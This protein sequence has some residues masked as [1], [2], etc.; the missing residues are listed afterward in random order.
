[1][2]ALSKIRVVPGYDDDQQR[3]TEIHGDILEAV[4][5][6]VPL[7]HLIPAS[8]V[9]RSWSRAVY[10]SLR[11]FNPIKPW[12]VIH[13]QSTRS[14]YAATTRAYDPRS[15]LWID[16]TQTPQIQYDSALRS[17]DSNLLYMLSQSK[18]SFSVD[19][20][21]LTWNHVQA[22]LLWRTDPIVAVVGHRI[23]VAG[24]TCDFEEDPFAVE[25]Y[26]LESNQWST[27]VS[28]PA[29]LKG[30]AS[31]SWLSIATNNQA[32]F[33]SEKHSGLTHSFDPE[34]MNWSDPYSLRPDPRICYSVVGFCG[35]KLILIGLI[36]EAEEVEG[37]KIWEVDCESMECE[38]IGEM[39]AKFVKKL[40]SEMFQVS[41][42]NVCT[43]GNTAY[44][45][46][47]MEVEEVF[48]CEFT[49]GG[50]RWGNI[51]NIDRNLM[52]RLVLTC[53]MVGMSDIR[54]AMSTGDRKF[55]LKNSS[56]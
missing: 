50:C 51:E 31:S 11:H 41:S 34:T 15:K 21:H 13:S 40:K 19:P 47:P 6:H 25:I 9:S 52:E 55:V 12:L 22:P 48:I 33:I 38:E 2:T 27:G 36:G 14:P 35:E 44:M 7:I 45:Y 8:H 56:Q 28:M 18:F 5:C 37:V 49:N 16:V 3:Q 29:V 30:S 32:L 23:V 4:L 53:S 43:V 42:I 46:N 17:S 10:S 24:G 26:D 1:M 20:L 39:P 54:N